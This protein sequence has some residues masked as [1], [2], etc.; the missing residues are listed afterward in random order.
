MTERKRQQPHAAKDAGDDPVIPEA[1]EGT[2]EANHRKRREAASA[3]L[4]PAIAP[5]GAG[6]IL[7][8]DARLDDRSETEEALERATATPD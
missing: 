1:A 6:A 3:L 7:E 5:A 4:S 2:G 8:A